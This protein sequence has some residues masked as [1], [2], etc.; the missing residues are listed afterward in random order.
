MDPPEGP[1][2]VLLTKPSGSFKTSN[3]FAVKRTLDALCGPL[4]NAKV[5]NSGSLLVETLNKDQTQH[6]LMTT[7]FAGLPIKVT[8]S[9]KQKT[10]MGCVRSE[11]LT[12]MTNLELLHELQDQGVCRVERLQ[13]RNLRELGPNPT[14]KLSSKESTSRSTSLADISRSL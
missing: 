2:L 13:S 1:S 10:I 3:P 5:L 4:A 8:L 11:A 14:L 7:T 12:N 6:L 9:N